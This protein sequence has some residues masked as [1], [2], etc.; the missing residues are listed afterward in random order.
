[1][2]FDNLDGSR[3]NIGQITLNAAP[4]ETASKWNMTMALPKAMTMYNEE[5]EPFINVNIGKQNYK[6]VFERLFRN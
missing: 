3:L 6:G 5:K 4:T 1:M 2:Y